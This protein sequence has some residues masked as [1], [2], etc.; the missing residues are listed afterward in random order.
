MTYHYMP[1]KLME[2]KSKLKEHIVELGGSLES[3]S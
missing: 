3:S 2:K 1:G